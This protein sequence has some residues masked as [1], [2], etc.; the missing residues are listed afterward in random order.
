MNRW[1]KLV[2]CC[3]LIG[4]VWL[5]CLPKLATLRTVR[6]HLQRVEE[7]NINVS[8]MFYTEIEDRR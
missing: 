1:A 7:A 4:I 2:L 3:V 8:A 5:V 6:Q